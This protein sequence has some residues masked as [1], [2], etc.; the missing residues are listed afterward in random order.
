MTY[1][2]CGR[3]ALAAL[4]LIALLAWPLADAVAASPV[5]ASVEGD[6]PPPPRGKDE[7]PAARYACKQAVTKA[8]PD[9]GRFKWGMA[10]T[11]RVAEDAYSV[12]VDVEYVD[13]SGKTRQGKVQCDTMRAPGDQFIVPKVRLPD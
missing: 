10:T 5:V 7:A 6:M 1:P 13:A 2:A 12:V 9:P 3:H 11:R 4:T 8:L